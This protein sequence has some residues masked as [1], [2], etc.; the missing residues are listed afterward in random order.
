MAVFGVALSAG[1]LFSP[2]ATSIGLA[3]LDPAVLFC[4]ASACLK[5]LIGEHA[6][7]RLSELRVS[8]T[9]VL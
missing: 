9:R 1:D 4:A 5:S 8:A 2:G 3:A 6:A 7:V